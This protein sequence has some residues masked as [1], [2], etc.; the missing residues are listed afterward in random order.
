MTGEMPQITGDLDDH[1]IVPAFVGKDKPQ[2]RCHRAPSSTALRSPADTNRH[3]IRDRLP[4]AYL[5][6]LILQK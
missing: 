4:N 6:E 1:H 3:V 5:L 2:G